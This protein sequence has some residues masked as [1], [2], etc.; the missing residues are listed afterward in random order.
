ERLVAPAACAFLGVRPRLAVAPGHANVLSRR[1][2]EREGRRAERRPRSGRARPL[3]RA[4]RR[5]RGQ[6]ARLRVSTRG[7]RTP[8][9]AGAAMKRLVPTGEMTLGPFFPREF[10]TG[11]N[12][13]TSV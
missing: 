1:A 13:L 11:A 8:R 10:G 2:A 4:P 6:C 12:D 7:A 5:L 9:H 3:H